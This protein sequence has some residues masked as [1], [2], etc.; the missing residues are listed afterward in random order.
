MNKVCFH[1]LFYYNMHGTTRHFRFVNSNRVDDLRYYLQTVYC[2]FLV[3]L[4]SVFQNFECR[5]KILPVLSLIQH[6]GACSHPANI[7]SKVIF[8]MEIMGCF[9]YA[10]SFYRLSY[11]ATMSNIF[12]L[13]PIKQPSR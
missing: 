7:G 2:H 9:L 8:Y 11:P 13:L 5:S 10:Q 4:K 1:D 6:P 3:L 12:L